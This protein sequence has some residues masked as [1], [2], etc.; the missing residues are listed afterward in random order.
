MA[1]R[2]RTFLSR[3]RNSIRVGV[4]SA[5]AV[6]AYDLQF[7]VL[8]PLNE[9]YTKL[10]QTKNEKM[11][12]RLLKESDPELAGAIDRISK[13]VR[14][15]YDGIGLKTEETIATNEE[16][17]TKA[18]KEFEDEY[19]I[20]SYFYTIADQLQT[21][22][23]AVYV[24]TFEEGIGLSQFVSLPMEYLT[25]VETTAQI[26][27]VNTQIFTA[28]IF[29][30]NETSEEK[31]RTWTSDE[32]TQFSLNKRAATVYDLLRRYTYGVWSVSPIESLKSTLMW[33]LVLK[34][35]DI[36]L[37]QHLV[38]RQHHK[39]DLSAFNPMN[40]PG[41]TLEARFAAAQTAAMLYLKKYKETVATPMKQV[42]KSVITGMDVIIE[43]LE[44]K[45]VSYVDP[46]NL[47][48]EINQSIWAAIA[49]IETAVTGRGER[50]YASELVVSS[51]SILVAETLGDIIRDQMLEIVKKHI[52]SKYPGVY[53]ADLNNIQMNIQ[54]VLGIERGERIRQGAVMMASDALTADEFRAM[55]GL[56]P[57][58]DEQK[59]EIAEKKAAAAG[60]GRTGQF[61]RTMDDMRSDFVNRREPGGDPAHPDTPQSRRDRQQT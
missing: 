15:S 13:M 42:D 49:P 7:P 41:E 46:N 19:N 53:D 44:P 9:L 57:L 4:G 47:V 24:T 32:V 37:R 16:E 3:V 12:F 58:T 35:N 52:Q 50:S 26:T 61:D 8:I 22:G 1:T 11:V 18:L 55:V 40:F 38:P 21:Y 14:V 30:L 31:Q 23:D 20:Q 5:P 45:G 48:K 29:V 25:A 33:K 59:E 34:I 36:M 56:P 28:N 27:D 60:P 39:I 10:S 2:I 17:L 6:A 51:Y 43:Y 54:L